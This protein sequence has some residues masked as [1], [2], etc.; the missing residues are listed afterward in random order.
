MKYKKGM[1][2]VDCSTKIVDEF[3]DVNYVGCPGCSRIYER[4]GVKK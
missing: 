3:P 1:K 4:A 2:C